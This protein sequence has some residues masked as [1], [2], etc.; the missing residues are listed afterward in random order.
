MLN[1]YAFVALFS[2]GLHFRA[3][4]S[5]KKAPLTLKIVLKRLL[6][7]RT[8]LSLRSHWSLANADCKPLYFNPKVRFAVLGDLPFSGHQMR[9][10]HKYKEKIDFIIIFGYIF[11]D[12]NIFI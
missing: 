2:P 1:I 6:A 8:R 3:K 11:I 5:E 12:K 4:Y 10:S 7:V 9:F